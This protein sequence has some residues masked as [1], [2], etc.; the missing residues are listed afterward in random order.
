MPSRST[1]QK[2]GL[3]QLQ[4]EVKRI[5]EQAS[6]Q[7]VWSTG[8]KVFIDGDAMP[9]N[10]LKWLERLVAENPDLEVYKAVGSKVDVD[11]AK[12]KLRT[13][14]IPE[15][16]LHVLKAATAS[17]NAA[18]ALL[19]VLYGRHAGP[20]NVVLSNDKQWFG[21]LPHVE[22]NSTRRTV[23]LRFSELDTMYMSIGEIFLEYLKHEVS[24]YK[25]WRARTVANQ[26]QS[27]YNGKRFR[28]YV[29]DVKSVAWHK[30]GI[31][32]AIAVVNA[33]LGN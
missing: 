13:A 1:T 17:K 9:K 30:D 28:K 4:T 31:Q 7:K 12:C 3:Q 21:E 11:A 25:Q 27:V 5:G 19:S 8:V 22:N 18:D 16:H 24:T 26:V 6:S 20:L 14:G 2:V 10:V 23:W 29:E 33:D 15:S 32:Q